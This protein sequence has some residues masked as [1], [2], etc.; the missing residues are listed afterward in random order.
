[1]KLNNSF[2]CIKHFVFILYKW[3]SIFTI[4]L[5]ESYIRRET[6][7]LSSYYKF[8]NISNNAL[9]K[10]QIE[11]FRQLLLVDKES[12][13]DYWQ[14]HRNFW[15]QNAWFSIYW[16][17]PF[18]ALVWGRERE[19]KRERDR[20]RKRERE[21]EKKRENLNGHLWYDDR[22]AVKNIIVVRDIKQ[23]HA[24]PFI[25]LICLVLLDNK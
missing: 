14:K 24:I 16:G 1:M 13:K 6:F 3:F 8:I 7:I 22:S 19:R 11:T 10:T 4:Q 20:E 25:Y 2:L 23:K 18:I 9:F 21:R 17:L 15:V 12:V 5:F